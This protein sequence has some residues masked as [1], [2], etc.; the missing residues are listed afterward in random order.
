METN[1]EVENTLKS[2]YKTDEEYKKASDAYLQ[3]KMDILKKELTPE[4]FQQVLSDHK[5]RASD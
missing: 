5:S 4:E 2:A 3:K 1:N